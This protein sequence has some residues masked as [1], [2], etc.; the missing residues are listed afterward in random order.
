[1]NTVQIGR[2][3]FYYKFVDTYKNLNIIQVRRKL[4]KYYTKSEQNMIISYL[5]SVGVLK[6]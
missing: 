2:F 5:K 1:M 4:K 3:K 6:N